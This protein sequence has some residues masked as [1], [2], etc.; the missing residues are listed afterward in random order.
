M[1]PKPKPL[2]LA[3]QHALAAFF[4]LHHGALVMKGRATG[5]AQHRAHRL[6]NVR[7]GREERAVSFDRA[8]EA[9]GRFGAE[10]HLMTKSNRPLSAIMAGVLGD[11]IEHGGVVVRH[12]GGYWTYPGATPT[13][14]NRWDWHCGTTTIEALVARGELV[15]VEWKEGRALRGKFPIKA[16][17]TSRELPCPRPA[18]SDPDDTTIGQCVDLGHCGCCYGAA[19]S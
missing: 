3:D 19:L 16:Q 4:A 13:S 1:K 7:A 9:G 18:N 10:G 15:Y 12:Q 2:S 6:G 5:R 8:R 11:I 17:R 14:R